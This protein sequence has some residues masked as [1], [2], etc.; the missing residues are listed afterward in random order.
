MSTL[1]GR[2]GMRTKMMMPFD[3]QP[4]QRKCGLVG[5][6]MS[7]QSLVQ[8]APL[9]RSSL[10]VLCIS[11]SDHCSIYCTTSPD[12]EVVQQISIDCAFSYHVWQ[13]SLQNIVLYLEQSFA[14]S[15]P[16][17]ISVDYSNLH[18]YV[19]NNIYHRTP[20]HQVKLFILFVWVCVHVH[21]HSCD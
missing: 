18:A 20:L 1:S 4:P 16:T 8:Q 12:G 10:P 7:G 14:S 17:A 21:F 6:F 15:L 5:G 19:F 9:P 2:R 3:A 13:F 11:V